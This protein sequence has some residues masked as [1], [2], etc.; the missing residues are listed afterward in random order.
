VARGASRVALDEFAADLGDR[1]GHSDP[2][3][4]A[5]D[6]L[7]AKANEFTEPHAGVGE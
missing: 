3:S 2:A 5:V 1:T 7:H 4:A 6:V